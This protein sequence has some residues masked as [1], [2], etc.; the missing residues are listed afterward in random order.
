MMWI[1]GAEIRLNMGL[2]KVLK[3]WN[4]IVSGQRRFD[5]GQ[6]WNL[7]DMMPVKYDI[8][9]PIAVVDGVN[10]G[11]MDEAASRQF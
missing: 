2:W 9:N 6:K 4:L 7:L 8:C 1:Q 5:N 11:K 3:K 10:T